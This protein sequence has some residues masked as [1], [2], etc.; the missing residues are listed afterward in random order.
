MIPTTPLTDSTDIVGDG[1]ALRERAAADG[2]ILVRGLLPRAAVVDAAR[3]LA[4]TMAA[5]GWIPSGVPLEEAPADLAKFCVEPQP[6]FMTVF[7]EQLSLRCLHA[8]KQ[9]ENLMRFFR[10]LFDE[11]PFCPPHFVTRLAFPGKP[12]YATPAHQDYVHFEGSSDNWAAWIPFIEID[13]ARGGLAVAAGS[14]R[15]GVQDMRP[16]LGAGQMVIDAD[17]ESLDWRWSPMQPGDVLIHNC[18]TIHRGLPN[19]SRTMRV[20]MDSR[21]QP[22]SAPIGEKFLGVSHQMKDWADLYEG[23]SDD[24]Y[25]YYWRDLDLDIVPFTYRWYDRRDERAI[26]MG[27]A[28][29]PEAAVALENITLKHRDPSMRARAEAAL[30][31]LTARAGR[32]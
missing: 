26:A 11:T 13:A 29:D 2:Y 28:G 17:L 22:L 30:A 8:L 15:G 18:L 10:L 32:V 5:A 1:Q 14:H 20:S 12:D 21:Y 23:W 4:D 6:A 27:E 7:Y 24:A 9:H 25:K 31:T 19:T 16:A 3:E